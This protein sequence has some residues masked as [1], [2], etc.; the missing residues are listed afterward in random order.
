MELIDACAAFTVCGARKTL[1]EFQQLQ[2]WVN[3]VLNIFP[4]LRPTLCE[5]YMKISGKARPNAPIRVNNT[6][7]VMER[8]K[9]IDNDTSVAI[10]F[11]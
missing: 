11:I 3:W 9:I 8:A 10:I 5:S 1:R 6:M 2:K 4:H 7:S